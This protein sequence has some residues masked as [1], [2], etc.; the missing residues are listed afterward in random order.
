[1]FASMISSLAPPIALVSSLHVGVEAAKDIYAHLPAPELA[2][3]AA[4]ISPQVLSEADVPA[5]SKDMSPEAMNALCDSLVKAYARDGATPAISAGL[6]QCVIA[7]TPAPELTS[8]G[9]KPTGVL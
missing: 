4:P 1:M 8:D 7:P 6:R 5:L 3:A 2:L 9:S